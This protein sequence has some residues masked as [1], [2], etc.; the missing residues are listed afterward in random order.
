MG[1]TKGEREGEV[2]G[3]GGR[4][5]EGRGEYFHTGTYVSLLSALK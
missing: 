4:E 2:K 1:G 5:R 3:R